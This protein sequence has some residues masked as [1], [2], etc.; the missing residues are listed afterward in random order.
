MSGRT[1]SLPELAHELDIPLEKVAL[2]QHLRHNVMSLEHQLNQ[3]STKDEKQITVED[4]IACNEIPTPDEDAMSEAFRG[5]VHSM[6][7][8]LGDNERWVLTHKFGLEDGYPRTLREIS[9]EMCVSIDIVKNIETKALNKLRQPG[10]MYRL[11]DYVDGG[12]SEES[13]DANGYSQNHH[14]LHNHGIVHSTMHHDLIH[15]HGMESG[16]ATEDYEYIAHQRPIINVEHVNQRLYSKGVTIDDD[17]DEYERPT[18]ES[19][20]SF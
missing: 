2:Y 17:L 10:M 9:E 15:H 1:P 8:H 14:M 5:E 3:H 19:I 18:P 12:G 16:P 11:K 13:W 20:W 4:R 7:D 6:L